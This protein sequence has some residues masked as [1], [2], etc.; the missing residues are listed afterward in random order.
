MCGASGK[1][2]HSCAT[3]A[4]NK[5]V[6]V[7]SVDSLNKRLAKDALVKLWLKM[8]TVHVTSKDAGP[9]VLWMASGEVACSLPAGSTACVSHVESS[10][11]EQ[12]GVPE[13]EQRLFLDGKELTSDASL[14]PVDYS[15]PIMLVRTVTDPR[16]TDL[17]HFH[18]PG[19]FAQVPAGDFT[20]VRKLC[21]GINGDIFRYRCS[22]EILSCK[23]EVTSG[24]DVAVKKLRNSCLQC[25]AKNETNERAAHLEPWKNAP[26]EEDALT[27]IGVLSYLSAQP[28]LPKYLIRMLG[29]FAGP[30]H[31]WLVTEFAD[32][33]ELFDTVASSN[34][35]D[36]RKQRYAWE[37]LQAVDYLH[38]HGIGHRDI[39]LE[40]TLLKD[41]SVK[42]MDFGL[43]VQSHTASGTP[44]RYFRPAG[45]NFYRPPECY[46]PLT[47][48]VRVVPPPGAE[49]GDIVM[50]KTQD[51]YLCEVRLP[52]LLEGKICKAEVWGY[53]AQP[54]DIFA[55]GM[56]ICILCC[57][58][59]I[60]EKAL[61]VDPT[62]AYVHNLGEEGLRMLLQRWNKPLPP[63]EALDLITSM[64]RT[65]TPT[66][67]PSA[68]ECLANPWFTSLHGGG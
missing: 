19:N 41:D 45:K 12:T 15:S 11:R 65:S 57:G 18:V 61:L 33:G 22:P 48:E 34:V 17:S 62:F 6:A 1:L 7:D 55:A 8:A 10:V 64:L 43:A 32:G 29:C 63:S 54:V 26:P 50:V 14:L 42:L 56:S 60:W 31:T 44:L 23:P 47:D 4:T 49:P 2:E 13:R 52:Q 20:L 53:A 25:H 5:D 27:E 28:D 59:P 40:N 37:L 66:K 51:G 9:Q 30:C 36:D 16:V 3:S 67:R 39:S 46:V 38:G 58:F 24:V 21:R 68:K 35:G